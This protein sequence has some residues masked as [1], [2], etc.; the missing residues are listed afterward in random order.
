MVGWVRRYG[1]FT[2]HMGPLGVHR[3]LLAKDPW[4]IDAKI[5]ANV[6][7]DDVSRQGVANSAALALR[8]SLQGAF[9]FAAEHRQVPL[10]IRFLRR[11]DS[12][13]WKLRD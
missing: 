12:R 2:C 7:D 10:G 13:F 11:N 6:F 3:K 8:P 9:C 4:P 1:E 5:N